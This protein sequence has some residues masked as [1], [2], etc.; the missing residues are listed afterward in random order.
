MLVFSAGPNTLGSSNPPGLAP[1]QIHPQKLGP[2]NESLST[3]F[4]F[5]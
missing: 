3:Y 2:Q 4:L 1:F 5:K